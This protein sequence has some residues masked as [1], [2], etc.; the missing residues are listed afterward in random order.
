MRFRMPE[1]KDPLPVNEVTVRGWKKFIKLQDLAQR[2]DLG[3]ISL[4]DFVRGSLEI[5]P[6]LKLFHANDLKVVP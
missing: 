4:D 1:Y 2:A 3:L 5:Q 6:D